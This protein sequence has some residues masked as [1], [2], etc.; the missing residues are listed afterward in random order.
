M[1]EKDLF[2]KLDTTDKKD[3]EILDKLME[4][5]R[6]SDGSSDKTREPVSA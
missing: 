3:I 5:K 4:E 6:D 2:G 1:M